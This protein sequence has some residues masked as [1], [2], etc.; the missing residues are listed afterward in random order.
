MIPAME[1]TEQL[2]MLSTEQILLSGGDARLTINPGSGVNRY[3]CGSRPDSGVIAFGSSTASTISERG[4]AAAQA[5]RRR[6]LQLEGEQ[7]EAAL[8]RSELE[9]IRLELGQLCAIPAQTEVASIFAA[10]GTDLHLIC[11]Q[12]L[13]G[14]ATENR[15]LHIIMMDACET[16]SG[17]AAALRGQHFS[18]HAAL[19]GSVNAFESL[20]EARPVTV[21]GI[22]LRNA[23]GQKRPLAD[24]D[25][26][27]TLLINAS[28][29]RQQRVLLIMIDV[30]K[31]GL[32]APSAQCVADLRWRHHE[33]VDVL[34]DA[35]QFRLSGATLNAYLKLGCMVM[36]T[37]SKFLTGPVFSGV[38]QIPPN[39]IPR[40]S[41]ATL[42]PAMAA[43]SAKADWPAHWHANRNLSDT[44]NWGLLLRLEAALAELR[45]FRAIPDARI[46]AFLQRFSD[47]VQN[48]IGQS[49][50][51]ELIAEPHLNRSPIAT[52]PNWDQIPTIFPFLL[53]HQPGQPL[54]RAQTQQIYQQL[55]FSVQCKPDEKIDP[56]IAALRCQLGQP[57]LCGTQYG[58]PVSALRLCASARLIIE[59]CADQAG[60]ADRV[61]E[62][63]LLALGK[64]ENLIRK[65]C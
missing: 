28:V 23:S 52:G 7:T 54:S 22:G 20:R 32:I 35:C 39:L 4:F 61:I 55:Q 31:T 1:P 9:R 11:A 19:G 60:S 53:L 51:F 48:E 34:V 24:I 49:P 58:M 65:L 59:A 45:A 44:V 27:V 14:P 5:L 63:A 2:A 15:P 3:G 64:A 46:S 40:L 42:P 56:A 62:R 57:V 37:G 43:Y 25:A 29:A 13:A 8:Y 26:E 16:G 21:T 41:R 38:L 6:L 17:V 12:L 33:L 47:T 30:S 50:H 10:S 36:L 18:D